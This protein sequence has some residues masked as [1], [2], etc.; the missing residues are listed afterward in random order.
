MNATMRD[1]YEVLGVAKGAD[2]GA[3][4]KAFRQKAKALHP[5]INPSPEAEA[6]FK[7]LGEAYSVLSDPDKRQIYD[8]YGHEGLKGSGG[9][10]PGDWGF[11]NDFQDLSDIFSAFFGGGFG[12]GRQ[13][14]P[15]GPMQGEDLR[16]VAN[17]TFMEAV[18]GSPKDVE[19]TRLAAC[20]PCGGTGAAAGSQPVACGTCGGQGQVRQTAQTLLGAFTQV[21]TCPACHGQGRVIQSPCPSCNG[22]ARVQESKTLNI[23]IPAG[24]DHGTRLRLGGEGNAGLFGGPPGDLYVVMQVES[25]TSFERDGVDVLCRLPVSYT[26]LVLG[27]SLEI[28]LLKGHDTL[29]IPAGTANG[30]V[31]T[32]R[33]QGVPYLNNPNHRGDLHVRLE[34]QIPKKLPAEER[35]LLEKLHQVEKAKQGQPDKHHPS[36]FSRLKESLLGH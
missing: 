29:K 18:F 28:P 15:G 10:G 34:V 17:L 14:R 6:E 36:F 23:T 16:T 22:Q 25:S 8:T 33:H 30:H 26:Q 5:D 2:A 21:V 7:E 11:V 13:R 3:I 12:G 24:V 4:K 20:S 31:L 35:D 27:D 32:L 19:V 9:G 1:Y